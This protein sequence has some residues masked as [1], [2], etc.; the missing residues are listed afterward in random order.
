M[1]ELNKCPQCSRLLVSYEAVIAV[2]GQLFCS[3]HCAAIAMAEDVSKDYPHLSSHEAYEVAKMKVEAEAE[4]VRTED[5]LG[6]DLQDV[7]I[8][9]TYYKTVKL[10]RT[11]SEEEMIEAVTNMWQDGIVCA[12]PDDCDDVNFECALVKTTNSEHVEED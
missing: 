3:K 4:V 1:Q 11:L 6:E 7:Q 8:A 5:A 10:P 12:E 9:V 2:N